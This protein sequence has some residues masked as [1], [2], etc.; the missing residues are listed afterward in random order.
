[1]GN[2][3]VLHNGELKTIRQ[4]ANETG[5]S[6]MTVYMRYRAIEQGKPKRK[7]AKRP[8][9]WNGEQYPSISALA[10]ELGYSREWTRQIVDRQEREGK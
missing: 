3:L 7:T 2:K 10:R 1:M 5:E 6:Y 8:V 9:M 4:I